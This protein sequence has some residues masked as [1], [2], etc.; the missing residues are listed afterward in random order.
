MKQIKFSKTVGSGNDF[1]IIDNRKS[2][3]TANPARFVRRVCQRR[4]SVGADGVILIENSNAADFKLRI[5]NP[6]G[7]EPSMCGNGARC[8]ALFAF[9]EKIAG[10]QMDIETKAG[11]HSAAV[12]RDR[13]KLK[14]PDPVDLRHKI[15]LNIDGKSIKVSFINTGVPHAVCFVRNVDKINVEGIGSKIRYHKEFRPEGTNTNF[16]E[17][18]DENC[19]KLRTYERGVEGETLSCGTGS[20]ASA[21]IFVMKQKS[22]RKRELINVQTRSGEPLKV[23][24]SLQN[25]RPTNLYLEGKAEEVYKGV[26]R[27]T[28]YA[29]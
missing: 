5:F 25:D 4:L 15:S 12:K 2:V 20:V 26:I 29:S 13:V 22:G 17:E 6:D 9:Q 18:I 28:T 7:H 16:V 11:I 23:Y 21:I 24:F 27:S 10:R 1:I 19:I 8:A 14:L 3:V